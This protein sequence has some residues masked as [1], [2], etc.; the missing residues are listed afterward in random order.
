MEL[1]LLNCYS[2]PRSLLNSAVKLWGARPEGLLQGQ[3]GRRS[4][5]ARLDHWALVGRRPKVFEMKAKLQG[6][7]AW[8]TWAAWPRLDHSDQLLPWMREA[9]RAGPGQ[10]DVHSRT[11]VRKT[12]LPQ[13][14]PMDSLKKEFWESVKGF[15]LVGM[16][17]FGAPMNTAW[18]PLP[19][20]SVQAPPK[21]SRVRKHF[22]THWAEEI[23]KNM[24]PGW[25]S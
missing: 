14:R 25:C 21:L 13:R 1:Q 24:K 18:G 3:P 22:S 6:S 20:I 5:K 11:G 16:G 7:G 10:R 12:R 4:H 23:L 15:L 2:L 17:H 8:A 9:L 19:V